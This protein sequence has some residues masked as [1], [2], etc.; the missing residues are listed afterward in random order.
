VKYVVTGGAGHV[1]SAL[2]ERLVAR[3]ETTGVVVADLQTPSVPLEGVEYDVVDVRD[4]HLVT[5]FFEREAPDVV[6]HLACTHDAGSHGRQ[7]MYET[8]VVSTNAVLAAAAS[9][10]TRHVVAM[11][12]AACYAENGEGPVA[13][14]APLRSDLESD[15]ARDRATVDRLCQLWAARQPDRA[16]TIVRPCAVLSSAPDD[17]V[18]ALFVQFLHEDDFVDA[19]ALL[20]SSGHGGVFNVAGDGTVALGDC[21]RMVGLKSRSG[22]LRAISKMRSRNGTGALLED[23]ELLVA[24]PVLSTDRVREATGWKPRHTSVAAFSAAMGQRG[25]LVDA[26]AG[27]AV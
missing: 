20:A 24:T 6:V 11:S 27:P 9:A 23:L 15:L 14:S 7:A 16:M 13:E 19:L 4:V 22:P 10:G 8:N 17:R 25:R 3:D 5:P 21:A 12:S 2:V 1:G 26:A 18:A